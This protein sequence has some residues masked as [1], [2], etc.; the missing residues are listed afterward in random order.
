M[1]PPLGLRLVAF[2]SVLVCNVAKAIAIALSN[3]LTPEAESE[4]NRWY[5]DIHG[6]EVCALPGFIGFQRYR[7]SAYQLGIAA[8]KQR[9]LA[10]YELS[11]PELAMHSLRANV[12]NLAMSSSLDPN[13]VVVIVFEACEADPVL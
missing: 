13:S 11:D 12:G 2:L 9:Y 10:V 5:D 1:K 3:P 4:F 6:P 7:A 8:P